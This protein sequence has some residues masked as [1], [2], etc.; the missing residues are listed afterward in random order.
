M[1]DGLEHSTGGVPGH[2]LLGLESHL[3]INLRLT[4]VR[5]VGASL[6]TPHVVVVVLQSDQS[7][8][9]VRVP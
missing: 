9:V 6:V 4:A 5:S 7:I 2:P 3:R 8:Y 1:L